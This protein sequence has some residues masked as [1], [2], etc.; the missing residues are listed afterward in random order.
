M[1]WNESTKMDEKLKFVSRDLDS[2][3]I[4]V[5]CQEYR[6]SSVTGH[7]IP[8]KIDLI[9]IYLKYREEQ[10]IQHPGMIE[11]AENLCKLG[12]FKEA[13]EIFMALEN[14]AYEATFLRPC[15]MALKSQLKQ[16]ELDELFEVL[17][18]EVNRDNAHAIFNYGCVKVHLK[19]LS[20][21]KLLLIKAKTM[22][23]SHA[24]ELL[25]QL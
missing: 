16:P 8:D 19:D 3:K 24:E 5:L 10:V 6:I 21:A 4:A 22:G 12:H 7:M 17:E 11:E 23:I 18:K 14:G 1:L 2:D 25:L 15:Q 20:K 13:F 9:Q